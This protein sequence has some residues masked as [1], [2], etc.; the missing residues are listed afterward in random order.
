[1]SL[2]VPHKTGRDERVVVVD[3]TG[4]AIGEAGKLQVHRDATLHRAFSVFI[5]DGRGRFLL[6][7]RALEKYHSGGLWSN[8][9]CSHP[10]PDEA[11]ETAARRRLVEEMGILCDLVPLFET[12]YFTPVSNGLF[13]NEYVHVLAGLREGGPSPNPAEVMDS[14]W[15]EIDELQSSIDRQ[16][17]AYSVWFRKYWR[18]AYESCRDVLRASVSV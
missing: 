2:T 5:F 7:R 10:R 13:E 1:M 18:E 16:P 12:S 14:K 8:T 15:M 17:D 9:C 3:E 6:Q 11:V 4:R